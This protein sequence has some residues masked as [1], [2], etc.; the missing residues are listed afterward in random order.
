MKQGIYLLQ[1]IYL[2]FTNR[3]AAEVNPTAFQDSVLSFVDV[4]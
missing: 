1:W 4:V 2:L 3:P